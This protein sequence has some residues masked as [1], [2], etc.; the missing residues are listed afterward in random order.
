MAQLTASLDMPPPPTV[1]GVP[2]LGSAP[3]FASANGVSVDF[4]QR[5]QRER[6]DVVRFKVMN[7]SFYL[8]S[9]PELVR[10][11]LL[12]RVQEFHK[13]G[14]LTPEVRGLNRFVGRGILTADY[15][16]WRPQRKLITPLMQ[17]RHI[18]EYGDTMAR[19]GEG[20]LGRWTPRET[21]DIHAD[22]T[23]VTMWIIAET[24]FGI[25]VEDSSELERLLRAAQK[26]VIR[27]LT[28][29]QPAWLNHRNR[30]SAKINAALTELVERFKAERRAD[31]NTQRHDLLSILLETR[32]EN[33]EPLSDEF[34]RNNILTMFVAG[35]ETTANTLTWA[36]YYL[37]QNPQV[38]EELEREADAVLAGR[39]PTA[40]DLTRLTKTLM[41][42]KETMRIQPIVATIPRTILDETELGGY[43][44][45]RESVVLISPYVL[46]HDARRWASPD[47]FDPT[48]FSA[49]N[50]PK[51]HKYGYIPF[52][53]GPRI[54]IGNHFALME[55]QMLLALVVNRYRLRLA[56]DAQIEPL[57]QVTTS[58]KYGMPMVVEKR[59]HGASV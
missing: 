28:R 37:S 13:P 4:L 31:T 44:M 45:E 33:G 35:H 54:C 8:V 9:D 29:P 55:A 3:S 56:A 36:F 24:M 58:P 16:E 49:E 27:D 26:I 10:Q 25:R 22:M 59:P 52:G 23:L 2:L 18:A 38:L 50:E 6:G 20:L 30:D 41:V 19:M 43:R 40:E 12:E 46:H 53:G 32:D 48:R 14:N 34:I 15:A 57:R 51:I 1:R 7:R 11:V 21:R 39:L 5:L 42:I 47:V 17:P